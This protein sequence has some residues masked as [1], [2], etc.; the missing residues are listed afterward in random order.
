MV[1]PIQAKVEIEHFPNELS[2]FT[3]YRTYSRW[4]Y[5]LQRRENWPETVGRLIEYLT[6]KM[7]DKI[8]T[9][10][11]D[12]IEQAILNFEVMPSMRLLWTAGV[13]MDKCNFSGYNC[14]YT[15][16]D[17]PRAFAEILYIL[18]HGAGV[19]LSVERQFIDKLPAIKESTGKTVHVVVDDSKEGWATALLEIITALWA[20]HKAT[21]DLSKIRPMGTVLK[22]FGGRASG[23]EPLEKC[24]MFFSNMIE[25]HRGRRL[26]AVNCA[27]LACSVAD[28]V[29]V[30]G[31]RRSSLIIISDLYDIGMRNYKAGQFWLTHPFR[32][33]AN[34]SAA[35][36]HKPSSVEF[37][38]EWLALAE[39]GTGE[40]GM[41]VRAN[42]EKMF[43][44]R[45][46]VVPGMGCNPCAEI[47]LRMMQLCNLTEVVIRPNDTF[48]TILEKVRLATI[49]GTIQA[50]FT[51]F[52]SFVSPKWKQNCDEERLLGVSLTGQMDNPTLLTEEHLQEFKDYAIGVNVKYAKKLGIKRAAA[53]TCTKPSGTVSVLV[54]SSAGF[55]PRYAK[56][57]L[58]RVRINGSDPLF[59]MMKAQG[60]H[61]KPEV[62]E[63][64]KTATTWVVEFPVKAPETAITRHDVT[65]VQQLEQWLKIKQNWAEHTVSATIYVDKNEWFEVGNWVYKHFDQLSGLSFLPKDNGVYQLAPY[66]EITKERYEDLKSKE[67]KIDYSQLAQFE[68]ED[69]GEGA[70]EMACDGDKCMLK[71]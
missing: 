18:M 49:M 17:E 30:G 12:A 25:N 2:K 55:H 48:E 22:T 3:Y 32:K 52:G 60:F 41:F 71:K 62:N 65:A 7:G 15:A 67:V 23:P 20:G 61:F 59:K 64:E 27:D 63:T 46:K 5:D 35:Y 58:R 37:M 34:I 45:R 40:R 54:D 43:P 68:K 44:N 10:D 70:G 19:G 47:F 33:L 29:V 69:M 24:F 28:C 31:V 4:R 16:I 39:S 1:N 36:D 14:S 21:W 8:S 56:Y 57:Y 42:L 11:F 13:A 38:K 53:I 66:E 6:S 51:N 9:R 26:S 50:T